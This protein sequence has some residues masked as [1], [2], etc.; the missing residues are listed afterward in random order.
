MAKQF[1]VVRG[2]HQWGPVDDCAYT[3]YGVFTSTSN[4]GSALESEMRAYA[5][6]QMH[7]TDRYDMTKSDVYTYYKDLSFPGHPAILG[8]T[9]FV[10]ERDL[11][12]VWYGFIDQE[13][14]HLMCSMMASN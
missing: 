3:I 8:T 12:G 1:L 7:T 13:T 4:D 9:E 6:E 11:G 10:V 5:I 14:I 2:K